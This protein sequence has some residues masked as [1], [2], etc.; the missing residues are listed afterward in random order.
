M[1]NAPPTTASPPGFHDQPTVKPGTPP[2]PDPAAPP[3]AKGFFGKIKAWAKRHHKALWWLHSAY[4]LTLGIMVILFASKGFDYARALAATLG[5]AFLVMVILFR[6]F[7]QGE[8]QK[9]K[10]D[11]KKHLKI[12]FIGMTY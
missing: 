4:A 12:G 1:G 11:E 8:Q 3:P 2:P 7:G 5:G 6:V 10:R 9:Q